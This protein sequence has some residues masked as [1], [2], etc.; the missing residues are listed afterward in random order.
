M[1]FHN[2]YYLLFWWGAEAAMKKRMDQVVKVET[3]WHR[4]LDIMKNLGLICYNPEKLKGLY[5]GEIMCIFY[6]NEE[7]K[8]L[9]Q[10]FTNPIL[11]LS[12]EGK[13][14]LEKLNCPFDILKLQK[15]IN[16]I[17]GNWPRYDILPSDK[18]VDIED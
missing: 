16:Q 12:E 7:A 3:E 1:L 6:F 4:H 9:A 8:N 11:E 15:R 18:T 2:C 13:K 5:F 10:Y 17:G 14:V